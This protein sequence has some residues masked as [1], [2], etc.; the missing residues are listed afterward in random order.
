MSIRNDQDAINLRNG[1]LKSYS[2]AEF[3]YSIKSKLSLKYR[4]IGTKQF[5]SLV[6]NQLREIV[7]KSDHGQRLLTELASLPAIIDFVEHQASHAAFYAGSIVVLHNATSLQG[8]GL[9]RFESKK[10]RGLRGSF[11]P[12]MALAHE[13]FHAGQFQ[14]TDFFTPY[15]NTLCGW[16]GGPWKLGKSALEMGAIHYTNQIRL[17]KNLGYVRSYY[18]AYGGRKIDSYQD[19]EKRQSQ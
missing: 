13:L 6:R 8:R 4:V 7:Q 9:A 19:A 10:G 14:K 12:A 3:N 17:D 16:T 11:S 5:Q 15:C 1:L 2:P 18:E